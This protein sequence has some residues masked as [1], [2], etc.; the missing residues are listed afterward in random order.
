MGKP[1]SL[2][3]PLILAS[4]SPRRRDLLS[5]IGITPAAVA[6]ADVDETPL[7]SELPRVHAERLAGDAKTWNVM[8][9]YCKRDV[10]TTKEVFEEYLPKIH[11]IPVEITDPN[12]IKCTCG[13]YRV[14]KRGFRRTKT[15]LFQQYQCQD[16]GHWWRDT[17]SVR[18]EAAA[19]TS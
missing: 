14:Q 8:R 7:K 19:I 3:I 15:R 11:N 17:K 9:R 5:Q 1:T 4:A 6:P 18:G 16:C 10:V 12:A 13:S 2:L